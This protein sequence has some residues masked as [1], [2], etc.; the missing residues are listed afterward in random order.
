METI[1]PFK[2]WICLATVG[3]VLGAVTTLSIHRGPSA[4]NAII[5]IR[6]AHLELSWARILSRDPAVH[7]AEFHLNEAWSNLRNRRY[8][9]SVLSAYEALQR[10]RDIKSRFPPLSSAATGTERKAFLETRRNPN[11]DVPSKMKARIGR[12]LRI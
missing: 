5:A 8:E 4:R 10:L 9:Q 2:L 3:C 7:Q 11:A 12:P 6:V 1:A